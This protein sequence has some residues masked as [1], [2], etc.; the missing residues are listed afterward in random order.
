MVRDSTIMFTTFGFLIG[1]LSIADVEMFG[2]FWPL[3][4]IFTMVGFLIAGLGMRH[5]EQ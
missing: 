4:A 1:A 5:G 2:E 3:V